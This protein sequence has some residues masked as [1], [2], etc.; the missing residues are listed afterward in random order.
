VC[1]NPPFLVGRSRV[2]YRRYS[3][4]NGCKI[5]CTK[6]TRICVNETVNPIQFALLLFLGGNIWIICSTCMNIF[7]VR[8]TDLGS[9]RRIHYVRLISNDTVYA[10][11]FVTSL[12]GVE[13]LFQSIPYTTHT[14]TN[15]KRGDRRGLSGVSIC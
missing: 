4:A 7:P 14:E 10:A 15:G 9:I 11:W 3:S 1:N 12:C 5:S 13:L 8:P 2:D 6:A